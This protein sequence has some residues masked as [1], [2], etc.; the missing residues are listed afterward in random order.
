MKA[1]IESTTRIVELS[2][3]RARVWEGKTDKGVPFVCFVAL[4][5]V[6]RREDAAEF[7]SDLQQ[8]RAPTAAAMAFPGAMV[9]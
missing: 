1:T 8:H 2:G 6:D 9:L 4:C 5:A 7:E 3:V